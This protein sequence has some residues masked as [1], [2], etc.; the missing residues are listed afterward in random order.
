MVIHPVRTNG[1]VLGVP[2]SFDYFKQIQDRITGFISSHSKI[3]KEELEKLMLETGILTKDMGTIL[4]GKQAVDRGI[5][6][7]VGG[8]SMAVRKL[9]KMMEQVN[10]TSI[11]Q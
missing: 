7:E 1:M 5:I 10:K 3:T 11:R 8:I 9:R 6:D 4:V 2:Q